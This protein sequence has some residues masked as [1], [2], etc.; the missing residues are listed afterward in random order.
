MKKDKLL[1]ICKYI[2]FYALLLLNSANLYFFWLRAW[3]TKDVLN[4][5]DPNYKGYLNI[6]EFFM[7]YN[8]GWSILF[9]LAMIAAYLNFIKQPLKSFLWLIIP[10]LF[11]MVFFIYSLS[12]ISH[13]YYNSK[14]MI[15]CYRLA[16]KLEVLLPV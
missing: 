11:Y 10:I 3:R 2:S 14:R 9:I 4:Y 13:W 7:G 12:A 6:V 8:I 15:I 5:S 1:R 16:A